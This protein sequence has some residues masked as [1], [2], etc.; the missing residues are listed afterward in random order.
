M[1]NKLV[2]AS[3]SLGNLSH[4]V[5]YPFCGKMRGWSVW[6]QV[7]FRIP[8]CVLLILYVEIK[9]EAMISRVFSH[10]QLYHMEFQLFEKDYMNV[11]EVFLMY[12]GKLVCSNS[13][14]NKEYWGENMK[15]SQWLLA[16]TRNKQYRLYLVNESKMITKCFGTGFACDG[17]Q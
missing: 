6:N 9:I 17:N 5:S 8:I 4:E 16:I 15:S 12:M 11:T 3:F 10:T 14:R 13:D 1:R 2:V 7:I